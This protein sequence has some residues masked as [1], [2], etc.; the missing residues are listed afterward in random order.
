[1]TEDAAKLKWCPINAIYVILSIPQLDTVD[2][3]SSIKACCCSASNCMMWHQ[4]D[5]ECP[6]SGPGEVQVESKPAGYCGLAR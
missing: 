6:Q 4:T 5:N 2:G 3:L 1:M